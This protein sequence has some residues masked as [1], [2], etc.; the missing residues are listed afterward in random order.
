MPD[1]CGANKHSHAEG[2]KKT[3][4]VQALHIFDKISSLKT[5]DSYFI[6]FFHLEE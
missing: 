3:Y 5:S 6:G 1:A 4:V 2:S